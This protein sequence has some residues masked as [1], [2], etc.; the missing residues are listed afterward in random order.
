MSRHLTDLEIA[1]LFENGGAAAV[2][3]AERR[4]TSPDYRFR[5]NYKS[6]KDLLKDIET[7]LSQ[8]EKKYEF[9]VGDHVLCC[10]LLAGPNLWRV[11]YVTAKNRQP[12]GPVY[13]IQCCG[14]DLNAVDAS[15]VKAIGSIGKPKKP[16]AYILKN[17][18]QLKCQLHCMSVEEKDLTW[19]A[20]MRS[21]EQKAN[22][23]MMQKTI[24]QLQEEKRE[25][26]ARIEEMKQRIT[27]LQ[28]SNVPAE[29]S[30]V[31]L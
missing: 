9:E 6:A 16:D 17:L 8:D 22:S 23:I 11:G 21:I 10:D 31:N 24:R 29:D 1:K 13:S 20:H 18:Q 5:S 15:C 14:C 30:E 3:R 4:L 2:L 12:Q 7:K 25:M 28:N 26:E 27:E 19:N